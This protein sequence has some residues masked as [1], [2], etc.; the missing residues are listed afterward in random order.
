MRA[1]QSKKAF[2]HFWFS[3][4]ERFFVPSFFRT[5]AN[6][7]STRKKN[8]LQKNEERRREND[9]KLSSSRRRKGR[10]ASTNPA[11]RNLVEPVQDGG[12][13][14]PRVRLEQ[15]RASQREKIDRRGR[16]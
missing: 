16:R 6:S 5:I 11:P 7:T 4:K 10:S 15:R 2:L 3:K 8:A 12:R 9:R 13:Q 1:Q 14:P